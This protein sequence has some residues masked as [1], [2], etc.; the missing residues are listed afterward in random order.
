M[1]QGLTILG[2][3]FRK[4]LTRDQVVLELHFVMAAI[5]L[6][7]STVIGG[8]ANPAP[9]LVSAFGDFAINNWPDLSYHYSIYFMR[10]IAPTKSLTY[11]AKIPLPKESPIMRHKVFLVSITAILWFT[12][13]AQL[14]AGTV[15][16]EIIVRVNNDIITKSDYEKSK[17]LIKKELLKGLSGPELAKALATQEKDLLKTLIEEQL[18]VQ[19]AADLSLTADTDVIKFLDRI[20]KENNLPD[21]EALEKLMLQ[22][23]ID[24]VEFKQNI[25][26]RS[27]TQQ[28]LGREVYSRIQNAISNDEVTKYYEAHKQE[29]DRPEEVRIREIL[30]SMEGKDPSAIPAL[31]KKAQEAL[32]KAKGGEKFEELA[33]K[34]SDG[35]TAKEG[36]ELGFFHRGKMIKEIEDVAF[37]LRRG[38]VS[39]II[40]TKYGLVIIK[41][42]EKHEAGI[43]KLETVSNEIRDRLF[44]SKAQKA[45]QEYMVKLR[46]QSF[47]EVKP[48]YIDTGAVPKAPG[49]EPKQTAQNEPGKEKKGKKKK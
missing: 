33:I 48:G 27:L 46:K 43:Q 14:M 13:S 1:L 3:L 49:S 37:K 36:G 29:F 39:D 47:I 19:K 20:R 25:K 44:E 9:S 21:M 26:N 24:P 30:I 31:E 35:P 45:T 8:E 12:F 17:D 11:A 32:Q 40:K 42:E 18:L 4:E 16:E 41:V 15:F 28:V 7:R 34:Y 6:D 38:Q 23:G 22:Q 5:E 2:K 10:L